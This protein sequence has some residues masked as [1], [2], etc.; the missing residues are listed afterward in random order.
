MSIVDSSTLKAFKP[1]A[2]AM[3]LLLI[4]LPANAQYSYLP[5]G[6]TSDE[7][8]LSIAGGGIQTLA[9]NPMIFEI[10]SRSDSS[11]LAIG[12]FD[13]N[14][15]GMFDQGNVPLRFTLFADP[16]GDGTGTEKIAVWV[17]DVMPDNAWFDASVANTEAARCA[18][19]DYF[20]RL[21]AES[22]NP[23]AF[24][25]S[26]FK[27]R[28]DGSIVI[29]RERRVAFSA[30]LGN[31]N[32]AFV[33][34]P[35]WPSRTPTNY[36]GRWHFYMDVPIGP[37]SL[38]I[39]DGDFDRGSY[40]CSDNDS[41]DPDTPNILPAWASGDAVAEGIAISTIPCSDAA[42]RPTG[43]TTTSNPPDDSR[44]PVF[45]RSTGVSYDLI[46]PNG[47][48]YA[49]QNPSGNLEWEQ[50]RISTEAFDRSLMDYH[51]DALP[52]GIY[53]LSITGLD[54]SNLNA[55][56]FPYD[57]TGVDI[58]G[59]PVAPIRADYADGTIEGTLYPVTDSNCV[60]TA[61]TPGIPSVAVTIFA[62]YNNDGLTDA[63]WSVTTDAAGT[64]RFRDLHRGSYTIMVDGASLP[65][66]AVPACDGDGIGTP[67]VAQGVLTMCSRSITCDFGYRFTEHN[68]IGVLAR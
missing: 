37:A 25:W 3:L 12:I 7:K 19:G 46:D 22:T 14:T 15:G 34:Y 56:R 28:T 21:E 36:N 5:T 41:D 38:A 52:A 23:T 54:L 66:G 31:I 35:A 11:A 39:W 60:R 27:L 65:P 67:N 1:C 17:G 63:T 10:A 4:V 42:G 68:L 9:E 18:T 57:V 16:E 29:R 53:D 50:L 40:D 8:F 13:G 49:N 48:R 30:P 32:D 51:A 47:V 33:V 59:N 20:Y 26:S 2:A 45:R 24:Q 43:G 64:Y 44:N 62:D 55:I 61:E 6:N 58:D